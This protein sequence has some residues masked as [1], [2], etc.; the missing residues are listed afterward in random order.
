MSNNI[1]G[2]VVVIT[3]ASSGLGEAGKWAGISTSK[4]LDKESM[5]QYDYLPSRAVREIVQ[6]F[7]PAVPEFFGD[8]L[9]FGFIFGGFAK[10][11]AT[12]SH[13]IDMLVCVQEA[14]DPSV[15]QFRTWYY[16]VHQKFGLQPDCIDFGETL[17]EADLLKRL[18]LL[19][20]TPLRHE[21]ETYY[22]YE[23]ILWCDVISGPKIGVVGDAHAVS[24]YEARCSALMERWRD[25]AIIMLGIRDREGVAHLDL[26]RLFKRAI[27]YL[28]KDPPDRLRGNPPPP[29]YATG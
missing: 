29:R 15:H 5:K 8:T 23:S 3:G 28:K 24:E 13:D 12:A 16:D 10:G 14:R 11:Y 2:K 27:T 26:R 9:V 19:E 25:E 21:I 6:Q 7:E 4:E 20:A 22:E 18:T 1:E 17:V